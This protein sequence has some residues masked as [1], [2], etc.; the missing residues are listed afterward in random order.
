MGHTSGSVFSVAWSPKEE[1]ILASGGSDGSVRLWDVRKSSSALGVFDMEDSI[2]VAGHDGLGT[3]ARRRMRGRAHNGLVNGLV[4]TGNGRYLVSAG[5]DERIRVW[6]TA[7][8]ANTLANFGPLVRNANTSTL[9]LVAAPRP[10]VRPGDDIFFYPNGS[11]ILMYEMFEG[12][13]LKRLKVVPVRSIGS[14][15]SYGQQNTKTRVMALAWRPHNVELMSAH[16]DGTI[17]SWLPRTSTDAMA[18]DAE[19]HDDLGGEESIND[20]KRKRQS[21]GEIQ[22]DLSGQ[23]ITFT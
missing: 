6:D 7:V 13:L 18:D 12:R 23:R 17:R 5:H 15:T 19:D 20:R 14:E 22:R 8:G 2:G 3:I 9:S 21:L 10:L 11:E 16:G 1:H 4:W